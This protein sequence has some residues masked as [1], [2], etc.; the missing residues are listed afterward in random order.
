M[1]TGTVTWVETL[2]RRVRSALEAAISKRCGR[3]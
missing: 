3:C 2:E 1:T